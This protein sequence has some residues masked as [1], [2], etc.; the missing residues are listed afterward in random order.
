MTEAVSIVS[1]VGDRLG[2]YR[3][4]GDEYIFRI[5]PHCRNDRWN[6]EVNLEKNK[7][8]CWACDWG[9]SA[10]RFLSRMGILDSD[11]EFSGLSEE[12]KQ[13]DREIFD[14]RE[15]LPVSVYPELTE[16][17]W[18]GYF[19]EKGIDLSHLSRWAARWKEDSILFP[20]YDGSDLVYWVWRDMDRGRWFSPKGWN[21]SDV[22]WYRSV[23]PDD[24]RVVL[25]EGV[26]DGV[27]LEAAGY[28]VI[29][30]L[31]TAVY[32]SVKMFIERAGLDPVLFL[33]ADVGEKKYEQVKGKLGRFRVAQASVDDPSDMSIEDIRDQVDNAVQYG[34]SFRLKKRWRRS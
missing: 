23:R 14:L 24:E 33:D 4:S 25:V 11:I 3:V 22:V 27:K 21:K 5:C 28:N 20:L 30:L 15:W 9:G 6:C 10:A 7:W 19:R 2:G 34:L 29:V 31:G 16:R 12:E 32:D 17:E 18:F 1:R 8:H 26:A 13:P